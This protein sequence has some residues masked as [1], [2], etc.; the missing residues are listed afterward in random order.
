MENDF[1]SCPHCGTLNFKG[2]KACSRCHFLLP[3]LEEEKTAVA[4]KHY[5]VWNTAFVALV[6]VA[7]GSLFLLA[8]RL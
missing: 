4:V 1:V 6:L 3:I 8:F 7:I 2:K 5:R